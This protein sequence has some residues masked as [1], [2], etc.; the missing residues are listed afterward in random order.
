MVVDGWTDGPG[1]KNRSIRRG[2][3]SVCIEAWMAGMCSVY[4]R[5]HL[6]ATNG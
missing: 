2:E 3:E 6:S 5:E 1:L 4:S